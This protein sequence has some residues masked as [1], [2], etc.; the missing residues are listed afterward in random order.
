MIKVL[1]KRFTGRCH[2]IRLRRLFCHESG[3]FLRGF[4]VVVSNELE[5]PEVGLRFPIH[6]GRCIRLLV[7]VGLHFGR[8]GREKDDRGR[9][10]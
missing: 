2:S 6:R 8:S 1:A 10:S 3:L 5:H 7:C 9:D 4:Y